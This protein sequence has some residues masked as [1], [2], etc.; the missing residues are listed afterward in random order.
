MFLFKKVYKVVLNFKSDF[1]EFS[2]IRTFAKKSPSGLK[3]FSA[4]KVKIVS[5]LNKVLGIPYWHQE[6]KY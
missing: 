6:T 5:V 1:K 2:F 3:F 4:F